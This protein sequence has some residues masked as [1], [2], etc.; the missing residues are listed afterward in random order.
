[1]NAGTYYW[2]YILDVNS[3]VDE[4]SES[5]NARTCNQITLQE[6]L[7]DIEATTVSTSTSSAVMGDTITVQYRID[8]IGTDYTG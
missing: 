7:P 8:N 3:D 4:A 1:M 2:G 5:N 6:D